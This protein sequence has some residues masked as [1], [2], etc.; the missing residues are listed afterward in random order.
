MI[1]SSRVRTLPLLKPAE[2]GIKSFT[3]M[4]PNEKAFMTAPN[5]IKQ[6]TAVI[7]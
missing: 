3:T 2:N 6:F 5:V 7:Y 4:E 1:P